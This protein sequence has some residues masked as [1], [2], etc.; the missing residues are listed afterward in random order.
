VTADM[1]TEEGV[2]LL[3]PLEYHFGIPPDPFQKVRIKT[4]RW[5][6][7]LVVYPV[8]NIALFFVIWHYFNS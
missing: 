4:G 6:E 8:V 3:F 5:F 7:N 1:F 2:P